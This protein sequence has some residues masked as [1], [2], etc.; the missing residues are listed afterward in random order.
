MGKWTAITI[1]VVL[2]FSL[3]FARDIWGWHEIR[4][5]YQLDAK[6]LAALSDWRG[7][8]ESFLA[9][10]RDQCRQVQSDN[11]GTCGRLR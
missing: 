8:P 7:S 9:M 2:I 4:S 1:G 11:A 5:N 10:L 6:N 3:P